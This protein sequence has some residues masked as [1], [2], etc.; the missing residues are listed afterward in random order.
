MCENMQVNVRVQ[1]IV[2]DGM[3]LLSWNN[4]AS[5]CDFLFRVGIPLW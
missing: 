4:P 3:S 2:Q 5:E 1:N